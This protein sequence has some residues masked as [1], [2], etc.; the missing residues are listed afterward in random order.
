LGIA[1]ANEPD[2]GPGTQREWNIGGMVLGRENPKYWGRSHSQY[3]FVN[4]KS[5][6]YRPGIETGPPR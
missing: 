6:I 2:S 3:N 5:L 1:A 4:N